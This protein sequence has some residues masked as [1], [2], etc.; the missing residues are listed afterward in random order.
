[1]KTEQ[2]RAKAGGEIGANGEFYEGGKFI[3]TKEDRIKRSPE[4]RKPSRG[5]EIDNRVFTHD[6]P[7]GYLPIYPLL[8][9]IHTREG[10]QFRARQEYL[11]GMRRCHPD[12]D[13]GWESGQLAL[14]D[15]WNAGKRW[16]K[17][18]ETSRHWNEAFSTLPEYA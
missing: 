12:M 14:I 7:D 10:E 11:D 3:A 6:R 2:R 5:W 15:A 4:P 13:S 8:G 9:G 1:M 18:P 16:R 17:I